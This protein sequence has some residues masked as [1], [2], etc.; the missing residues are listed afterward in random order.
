VSEAPPGR[1]TA[2]LADARQLDEACYRYEMAWKAGQRPCIEEFAAGVEGALQPA[3]LAELV[4]LDVDYRLLAGEQ[5]RPEEYRARFPSLDLA[6]VARGA[7]DDTA[8]LAT[9]AKPAIVPGEPSSRPPPDGGGPLCRGAKPVVLITGLGSVSLGVA[10]LADLLRRRLLLV[11]AVVFLGGSF[12]NVVKWVE[13]VLRALPSYHW[14]RW[15]AP[16]A[17]SAAVALCGV[18]ACLLALR[19]RYSLRSL[20]VIEGVVFGALTGYVV[21][22][23]VVFMSYLA[24]SWRTRWGEIEPVIMLWGFASN[25]SSLDWFALL[26][27]YGLL[28]PNTG[29]RCAAVVAAM[30]G[31]FALAA[32]WLYLSADP[33]HKLL[34]A[35]ALATMAP[36]V[37]IGAAVAVFGSFHLAAL[38]ERA[39]AARKLG[40]YLLKR[41]LGAGG[42]GEVYLA[43]HVQ[44]R[45]PCALKL[46]R[47]DRAGDPRNLLRFEREVRA[48]VALTHANTV[49]VYD[50]GRAA[51]GTFYYAMEYLPGLT[52]Q[53]LVARHGP[54]PPA[55]VVHLLRQVCGALREAHAAGLTHR[56][57]KPGNIMVCERG[58]AHD[59]VKLLDFGLVLPSA[60]ADEGRLTLT[61]TILGTPA[62]LSPEQ[63]AGQEEVDA[64]SDL[65]SLGCVAYFLLAGRPPFAGGPA[66]RVL[67]AHLHETPDLVT[68]HAAGVGNDLEE[69]V[70]RCL[71]KRPEGRYPD[72][73]SLDAALARCS[74]PPWSEK[75]AAAWW[76]SHPADAEGSGPE[77]RPQT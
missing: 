32:T 23:L 55:R 38:R 28:I 29:S 50:Y 5:P 14:V 66:G 41:R 63:A 57:V 3:L 19:K 31:C 24:P 6:R 70:H 52:L 37:G 53:E 22:D 62:Y 18:V 59:V 45:R 34:V 15:T 21:L 2:D 40:Q 30:A 48:T 76:R 12:I 39:D 65:Y 35:R 67:A 42:M 20:R 8:A 58:G 69:V 46:I 51:D 71:A 73:E 68:S 33:W 43:E 77:P 61:G 10:D 27:A 74:V 54:L 64:R 49:Q 13:G 11:T 36:C 56:D 25:Y 16:V 9:E 72:A 44:L 17:E 75:E 7:G 1:T 47:P 60:F 26:V 4:A